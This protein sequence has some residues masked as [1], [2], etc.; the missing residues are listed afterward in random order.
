[1]DRWY[2]EVSS[3]INRLGGAIV[4]SISF[5]QYS[6]G[7]T[8]SNQSSPSA[9]RTKSLLDSTG[10]TRQAPPK[11]KLK[12]LS[13][14]PS[15]S[16]SKP[17]RIKPSTE[18]FNA[19]STQVKNMKD[20]NIHDSNLLSDDQLSVTPSTLDFTSE[21]I[22]CMSPTLKRKRVKSQKLTDG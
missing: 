11:R 19:G 15:P 12:F 4:K 6:W 13:S 21:T 17:K 5:S 7:G 1:L 14:S 2:N 10:G 9:S 3:L 16:I 18:E 8:R 22:K 20:D